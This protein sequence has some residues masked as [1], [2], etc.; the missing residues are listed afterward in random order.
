MPSA[1]QAGSSVGTQIPGAIGAATERSDEAQPQRLDAGPTVAIDEVDYSDIGADATASQ[2]SLEPAFP[3]VEDI[4]VDPCSGGFGIASPLADELRDSAWA[5]STE[6][7]ILEVIGQADSLQ[8]SRRELECRMTA[9]GVML[10]F[11]DW[12]DYQGQLVGELVEA[13]RT[14]LGFK[15]WGLSTATSDDGRLVATIGL[16][17]A[18]DREQFWSPPPTVSALPNVSG[19]DLPLQGIPQLDA[20]HPATLLSAQADDPDWARPM[21]SRVIADIAAVLASEDALQIE[22]RCRSTAC[23]IALRLPA[24]FARE[25][26]GLE[27]QFAEALGFGRG[28]LLRYSTD[29]GIVAAIYLENADRSA[30]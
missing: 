20:D 7:R 29:A 23:G 1:A 12:T 25:M 28:R 11:A 26:D 18:A 6:T 8:T 4:L 10:V 15:K 19:F 9:C 2:C 24:S 17:R 13:L 14:T 21:E 5:G 27:D 3:G 30:Q 22:A 16:M